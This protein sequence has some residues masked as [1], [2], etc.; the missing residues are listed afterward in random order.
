[1][2]DLVPCPRCIADHWVSCML[3]EGQYDGN[4]RVPAV[5]AIE[6]ALLYGED[7]ES[8]SCDAATALRKQYGL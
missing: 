7:D 2:D 6:Y 5:M 4:N 8:P 1:M 3:C